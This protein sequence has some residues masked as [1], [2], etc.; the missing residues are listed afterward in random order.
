MIP[1]Q[2]ERKKHNARS[3]NPSHK[4]K[5]DSIYINVQVQARDVLILVIKERVIPQIEVLPR[6][7][8]WVL[9]LVIKERVIPKN[10]LGNGSRD[11]VLILVIKERVIP[12][13]R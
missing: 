2:L 3:L 11:G 6:S 5:G 10:E 7:I 1:Q 4:G 9:I 13:C 8:C 12:W